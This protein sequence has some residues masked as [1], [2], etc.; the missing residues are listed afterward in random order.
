MRGQIATVI[1][2]KRNIRA[3]T[4]LIPTQNHAVD[5]YKYLPESPIKRFE[6]SQRLITLSRSTSTM[7]NLAVYQGEHAGRSVDLI[8]GETGD[9]LIKHTEISP[10]A[11][12]DRASHAIDPSWRAAAMV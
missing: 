8:A 10:L 12:L 7:K 11:H 4:V 5:K 2:A 6:N 3:E 9:V 1:S